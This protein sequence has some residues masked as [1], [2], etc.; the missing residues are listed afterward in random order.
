MQSWDNLN[1]VVT[2]KIQAD[3]APDIMN[4]GPFAGF[5]A[6]GLLYPIEDVVSR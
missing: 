5:A 1:D 4:G 3:E 2:T 6:D